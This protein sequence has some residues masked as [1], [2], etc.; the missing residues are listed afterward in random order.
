V[1][2]VIRCPRCGEDDRLHGERDGDLVVTTCDACSYSW[3][4]RPGTSCLSCGS[5]EIVVVADPLVD[6]SRGTQLSITGITERILCR[7]CDD[8]ELAR[9]RARGG[10]RMLFP[11]QLPTSPGETSWRGAAATETEQDRPSE[12]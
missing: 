7:T 5:S 1:G 2:L 3:A 9:H 8:D 11:E 12:P 6:R 4:R 10:G